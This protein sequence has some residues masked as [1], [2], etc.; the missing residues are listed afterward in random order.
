MIELLS[1]F[2][3]IAK[4]ISEYLAWDEYE[5]L[6]DMNWPEKSGLLKKSEDNGLE[7]K[8]CKPNRLASLQLDG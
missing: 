1:L 5:K 7:L 4:N 6:V 2:Y 3:D 8:W